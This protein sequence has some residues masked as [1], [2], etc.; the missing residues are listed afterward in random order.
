MVNYILEIKTI[1]FFDC[2][3]D[4]IWIRYPFTNLNGSAVFMQCA[5]LL[6]MKWAVFAAVIRRANDSGKTTVRVASRT[7]FQNTVRKTCTG[8]SLRGGRIWTAS[9][10]VDFGRQRC[11]LRQRIGFTWIHWKFTRFGWEIRIFIASFTRHYIWVS[12][13]WRYSSH[14]SLRTRF[15]HWG[16]RFRHCRFL[17]NCTQAVS[18]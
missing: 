10:W 18:R 11:K 4:I 17:L 13:L 16:A 6:V 2:I 5:S 1:F 14:A 8:L 12:F 3:L 15:R 9:A 7:Q